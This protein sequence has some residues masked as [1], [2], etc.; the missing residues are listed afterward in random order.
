MILLVALATLLAIIFGYSLLTQGRRGKRVYFV[1]PHCSGKTES[2]VRLLS[3]DNRTVPTIGSHTTMLHGVEVVDC[4]PN[5]LSRDFV[6]KFNINNIDR[7]IFF[8]KNEE[9]MSFFP[10]LS[11][12][13]VKFVMWKKADKKDNPRLIYLDES[14]NKILSLIKA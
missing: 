9:E 13:D 4:A 1:G 12:F 10:D 14:P 8:V 2:I 3:L 5:D 6:N 7:F 11:E